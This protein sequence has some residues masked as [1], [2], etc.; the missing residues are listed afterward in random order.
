MDLTTSRAS[1]MTNKIKNYPTSLKDHVFCQ[2]SEFY[3]KSMQKFV[4]QKLTG[5]AFISEFFLSVKILT[6]R[7]KYSILQKDFKR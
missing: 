1:E 7:K 4:S 3:L 6:D 5:A 2:S